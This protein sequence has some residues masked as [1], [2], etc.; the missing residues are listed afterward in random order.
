[1]N[2]GR[3]RGYWRSLPFATEEERCRRPAGESAGTRRDRP[4]VELSLKAF[5]GFIGKEHMF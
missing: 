1:M 2:L 5:I 4:P 3:R